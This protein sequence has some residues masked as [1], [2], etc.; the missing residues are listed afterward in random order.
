MLTILSYSWN[1]LQ[2]QK[3]SIRKLV[4]QYYYYAVN[5]FQVQKDPLALLS[6]RWWWYFLSY[7]N[8]ILGTFPFH[9]LLTLLDPG[10]TLSDVH[11]LGGWIE[12]KPGI[13]GSFAHF[14]SRFCCGAVGGL[15]KWLGK[16]EERGK[17]S[18]WKEEEGDVL[19]VRVKV[20]Y[21][22][23]VEYAGECNEP[24]YEGSR[25]GGGLLLLLLCRSCKWRRW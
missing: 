7:I 4:S 14:W 18:R 13:H 12:L 22:I 19:F 5:I 23:P 16:E 10:K 8:H 20:T 6:P 2:R 21:M 17:F 11:L 1:I 24:S 15:R 9:P 25:P 3:Q